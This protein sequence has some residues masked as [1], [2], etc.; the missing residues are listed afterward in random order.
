MFEHYLK[1]NIERVD[2]DELFPTCRSSASE[3][4]RMLMVCAVLWTR[5]KALNV[6]LIFNFKAYT[7]CNAVAHL[8]YESSGLD[9]VKASPCVGR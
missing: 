1:M 3:I 7:C 9:L 4:S 2:R 5:H 8:K 6:V